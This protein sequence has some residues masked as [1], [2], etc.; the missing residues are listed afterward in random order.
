MVITWLNIHYQWKLQYLFPQ[1]I[2]QRHVNEIV[3]KA[4]MIFNYHGTFCLMVITLLNLHYQWKLQYLFP[5]I[6][7][8]RHVNEIV[9]K[10]LNIYSMNSNLIV[11]F[12][13]INP[14]CLPC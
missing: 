11:V 5:Q 9:E 2:Y 6:I 14:K 13:H 3:E 7:Y 1:I 12:Y 4:L 8:Q 10:P